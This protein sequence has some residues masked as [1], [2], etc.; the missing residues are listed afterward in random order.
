MFVTLL[1]PLPRPPLPDD[2]ASEQVLD[3]VLALQVEH[4]LDPLTTAGWDL[5]DADTGPEPAA[6]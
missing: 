6:S 4:G 2:A 5:P 1:G 3:A